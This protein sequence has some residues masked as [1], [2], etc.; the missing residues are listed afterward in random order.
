[1]AWS[2]NSV[3]YL[4]LP[5][6]HTAERMI[7]DYSHSYFWSWVGMVNFEEENTGLRMVSIRLRK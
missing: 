5:G 4:T 1:M 6:W 2:L 7:S 3:N